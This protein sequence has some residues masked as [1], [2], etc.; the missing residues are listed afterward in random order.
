[1]G[2]GSVWILAFTILA[3][4]GVIAGE[5]AYR[6]ANDKGRFQRFVGEG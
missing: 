5:E 6:K 1:M 3:S 2:L 4:E